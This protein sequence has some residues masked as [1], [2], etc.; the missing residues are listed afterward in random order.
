MASKSSLSRGLSG[1][2]GGKHRAHR[3]S[4]PHAH[5]PAAAPP[6]RA[7]AP[8]DR[9]PTGRRA[10]RAA[11]RPSTERATSSS[12]RLIAVRAAMTAGSSGIGPVGAGRRVHLRRAHQIGQR[13]LRGSGQRIADAAAEELH[14]HR[15]RRRHRAR[16]ARRGRAEQTPRDPRPRATTI[17][18]RADVSSSVG[19]ERPVDGVAHRRE[20]RGSP[21]SPRRRLRR[22]DGRG[23]PLRSIT[24]SRNALAASTSPSDHAISACRMATAAASAPASAG[25]AVELRRTLRIAAAECVAMLQE[26]DGAPAGRAA[27]RASAER[28]LVGRAGRA[29]GVQRS[30]S[31]STGTVARAA[32]RTTGTG[33]P[34]RSRRPSA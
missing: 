11:R 16:R 4:R 9:A 5:A 30:M 3:R 21:R 28:L 33:R 32:A 13:T 1:A 17:A 10:G 7:R 12:P 26:G 27:R 20:R 6:R 29:R 18:A 22:G 8:G 14:R 2:S 23:D 34:L 19:V 25:S 31:R 15:E 24:A